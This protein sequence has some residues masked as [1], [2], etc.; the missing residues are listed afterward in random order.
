MEGEVPKGWP[1]KTE[2]AVAKAVDVASFTT[3]ILLHRKCVAVFLEVLFSVLDVEFREMAAQQTPIMV[4]AVPVTDQS[5]PPVH[6]QSTPYTVT[7]E[8][9]NQAICRGCGRLFTRAPGVHDGQAQYFRCDDC[10]S[11]SNVFISSC[12]IL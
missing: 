5:S 12:V 3:S 2:K 1:T 7:V 9:S 8:S 4:T 10:N 11:I 6:V